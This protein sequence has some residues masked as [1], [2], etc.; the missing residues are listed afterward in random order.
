MTFIL[1]VGWVA[2]IFISYKLSVSL[3]AKAG[4]L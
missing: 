3:L 2:V 1:L 4:K